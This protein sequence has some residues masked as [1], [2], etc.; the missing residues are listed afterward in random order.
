MRLL[1]TLVIA[2]SWIAPALG[3][4]YIKEIIIDGNSYNGFDPFMA[5]NPNSIMQPWN[6]G[7]KYTDW[8]MRVLDGAGI[9]CKMG[10][11]GTQGYAKAKPGSNI[12][13][14][15]SRWQSN[16]KGPIITYLAECPGD[17]KTAVGSQL[18]WFKVD[19]AGLLGPN[20]WATDRL[21]QQGYEWR[22]QLPKNIKSGQYLMR[23]E[24]IALMNAAQPNGAQIY[25]HC[26][27]VDIAGGTAQSNPAGVS[28]QQMYTNQHPG[29][30]V[31]IGRIQNYK[32]PGPPVS[33]Q[34]GAV[35][36]AQLNN[37]RNQNPKYS[38]VYPNEPT[39]GNGSRP[40]SHLG[41]LRGGASVVQ[42]SGATD[43]K[44]QPKK[45]Q[46]QNPGGNQVQG[47]GS[48][49]LNANPNQY[50]QQPVGTQYRGNQQVNNQF[51][52]Q[53]ANYQQNPQQGT[54]QPGQ[55][56]NGQQQSSGQNYQQFGNPGP[57][58]GTPQY[59][60]GGNQNMNGNMQQQGYNPNL[61]QGNNQQFG[62]NSGFGGQNVQ[63]QPV[64][65]MQNNMQSGMPQGQNGPQ[66]GSNQNQIMQQQA[67]GPT[68]GGQQVAQYQSNQNPQMGTAQPGVGQQNYNN[69]GNNGYQQQPAK[70]HLLSQRASPPF[71]HTAA[72]LQL[73]HTF[74]SHHILKMSV[75]SLLNVDIQKNPAGFAD[76]FQFEIT[77]ECLEQ[78]QKDL[79][80]KLIYVGSATSSEYDQELDSLL[81]GP[82]PVG[83]NKFIFEADP[84]NPAKIP[85]S[86]VLGVTVI[87]LTGA[88]DGREFIRV[89]YY[90][91]NEYDN[92]EMNNE[93]PKTVQLD[94]IVKNIL[95]DKPRVTRFAIKW[96]S[97]E[98]APAEFPP[99]QPEADLLPADG[100]NY[101][102]DEE[103]E[104]DAEVE[105]EAGAEGE[106]AAPNPDA[107]EEDTEMGGVPAAECANEEE[108]EGEGSEDIEDSTD[109]EGEEEEGEEGADDDMAMDEGDAAAVAPG[110]AQQPTAQQ[111][112]AQH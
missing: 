49:N 96:D 13:F 57:I 80:W 76:K 110:G 81:V 20:N 28:I 40:N 71:K 85:A 79:E 12:I 104:E 97:E 88:Y 5:P 48:Q 87:L 54:G 86:E 41:Y 39:D 108:S 103:E 112:I 7:G 58:Q 45:Q 25:P 14:R 24:L 35:P 98:S 62:G 68:Q 56:Q 42:S 69:N 93:P 43:T 30:L 95:K 38:P 9:V 90:V 111:P 99:E 94:R 107:M 15:W 74:H 78:L 66:F 52:N 73:H 1:F 29:L 47:N 32:I 18:K 61:Q 46:P 53:Q 83:V 27:N 3:H 33:Q 72:L 37:G 100:E 65:G 60:S 59:Q 70:K 4:A 92:P 31:N 109:E 36:S 77:F 82:I 63:Q 50:S 55:Y 10:A 23:H 22:I 34:L 84:P 21:M 11:K 19:E 2:G 91:S 105:A 26:M 17:C 102:A 106:A 16:H 67:H 101:G 44:M 6:T 8:P 64:P 89:G 75:V 51:Q